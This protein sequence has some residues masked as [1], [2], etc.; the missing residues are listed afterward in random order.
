MALMLDA[1]KALPF[2]FVKPIAAS[3]AEISRSDR[4]RP[5]SDRRRRRLACF[6][7]NRGSALA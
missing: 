7:L 5:F 6:D 3:A 4:W 2:T 1:E